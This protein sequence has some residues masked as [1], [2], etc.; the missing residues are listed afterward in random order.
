M[1]ADGTEI[2]YQINIDVFDLKV[3]ALLMCKG[4]LRDK[5]AY[6]FD[7]LLGPEKARSE[8]KEREKNP[9]NAKTFLSFK[10]GRIQQAFK[11]LIF[12]SEIFPKKYQ[13]EFVKDL[14][15]Q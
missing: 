12:F 4:S 3:F 7:L 1:T 5:A 9:K 14:L 6:L 10:G 15:H 13:N 8:R 2:I 11:R